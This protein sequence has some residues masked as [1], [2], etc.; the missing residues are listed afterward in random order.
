MIWKGKRA[1]QIQN[2]KL[3]TSAISHIWTYFYRI[4]WMGS[5]LSPPLKNHT[6]CLKKEIRLLLSTNWRAYL[7]F[8]LLLKI[9]SSDPLLG[10]PSWCQTGHWSDRGAEPQSR[11]TRRNRHYW[12]TWHEM[13]TQPTKW[14]ALWGGVSSLQIGLA[15]YGSLRLWLLLFQMLC[16][17]S[18]ALPNLWFHTPS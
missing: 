11:P 17:N 8:S 3:V 18:H 10:L 16:L 13:A 12:M 9:S 14:L 6:T 7:S 1:L 2:D 5:W 15:L 4:D